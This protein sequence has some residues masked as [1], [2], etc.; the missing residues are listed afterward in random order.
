LP[1]LPALDGL[2]GT[3]ILAVILF[4]CL[5]ST[6]SG[7]TRA[8][9]K[10]LETIVMF[11]APYS[12]DLFFVI[13]G[14]LITSILDRTRDADRPLR[15]FYARRALRIIPLYYGFLIFVLVVLPT[16]SPV[17]IGKPGS[18]KWEFLFLTNVVTGLHGIDAVGALFPHFWTLAI[19]EQFY[20]FWPLIV[21]LP[22]ENRNVGTCVFLMVFSLVA[23]LVLL[24]S[25][26]MGALPFHFSSWKDLTYASFVLTPFRMDGLAAG[27]AVAF[28]HRKNPEF[29]ERWAGPTMKLALIAIVCVVVVSVL[30]ATNGEVWY[31]TFSTFFSSIFFA[32]LVAWL[33]VRTERK[34][35]SWM[36][37]PFLR[38]VA[39]YS[40]GMYAFHVPVI[41]LL[42]YVHFIRQKVDIDGYSLPYRLYFYLVIT[43]ISYSLGFISW[44]LYEKKFLKL[45]P[46]YRYSAVSAPAVIMHPVMAIEPKLGAQA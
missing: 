35:P 37:A 15:T 24:L 20:I 6:R 5:L 19:E 44:H 42:F 27:A 13:S 33:A 29:L 14:F 9:D 22:R 12:M 36:V 18:M 11:V 4:H 8:I 32:A 2:R 21:L 1:R 46:R 3:A 41:T 38:S 7:Y 23:R 40:Y 10:S 30:S 43:G 16:L 25:P 31:R 34:T 26:Q 45:A 39:R 28:V 17:V